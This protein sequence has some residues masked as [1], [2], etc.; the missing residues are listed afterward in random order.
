MH[1]KD[2]IH[3]FEMKITYVKFISADPDL[4]QYVTPHI[5]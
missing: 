1:L 3:P 4:L 5:P 2:T